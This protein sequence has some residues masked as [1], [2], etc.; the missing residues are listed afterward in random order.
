MDLF[1]LI[2]G[3]GNNHIEHKLK[4]LKNNIRRIINKS[5]D[6]WNKIIINIAV[7]EDNYILSL[8]D[9][10]T[11][12]N[13]KIKLDINIIYKKGI[14]GEFIYEYAS[15]M[16]VNNYDYV[17][18]IL[19]DVEILDDIDWEYLLILKEN[20]QCDI[21]SPSMSK[22][23]LLE[24]KNMLVDE[25]NR[26]NAK[27]IPQCEYFCYIMDT[28]S[29]INKYYPLLDINNPWLWGIDLILYIVDIKVC[30]INSFVVHH[31]YKSE[32]YFNFFRNPHDDMINYLNKYKERIELLREKQFTIEY[33]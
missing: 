10:L 16:I 26:Y 27:I 14:V 12:I 32:S 19:D 2:T 11:T 33:Y 25:R 8:D 3:F 6:I 5:I 29:Y 28:N 1:I 17:M 9:L 13:K 21:I 18:F 20:T 4:I 7:Y 30:L 31:Y 23:S 22:T 15:P 24:N